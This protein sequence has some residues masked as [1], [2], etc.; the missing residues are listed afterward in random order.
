MYVLVFN[1]V[2]QALMSLANSA[3]SNRRRAQQLRYKK[4]AKMIDKMRE[5]ADLQVARRPSEAYSTSL[6]VKCTHKNEVGA[7][8][9]FLC[10][11]C[12]HK[13]DRDHKSGQ[14]EHI[15]ELARIEIARAASIQETSSSEPLGETL[16]APHRGGDA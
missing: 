16:A 3:S 11:K 2:A 1:G 4:A 5:N 13:E 7:S 6:C 10:R 15:Q 14:Q 12:G 9:K 8:T